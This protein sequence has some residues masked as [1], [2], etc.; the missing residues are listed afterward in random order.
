[1]GFGKGPR[2]G[3]HLA[4]GEL[5]SKTILLFFRAAAEISSYSLEAIIGTHVPSERAD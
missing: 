1:M 5:G 3:K 2:F 4:R